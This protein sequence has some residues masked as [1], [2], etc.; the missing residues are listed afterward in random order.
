VP[1]KKEERFGT[2][3]LLLP[4]VEGRR[5]SRE[6]GHDL[7]TVRR[8]ETQLLDL[9]TLRGVE[10]L[11]QALLLRL[12]IEDGE[13]A[14][15]GHPRYGSRLHKLIGQP[16][17]ESNRNLVKLYVLEALGAEPRIKEIRSVSVT[18]DPKKRFLVEIKVNLAAIDSDTPLNLVFPFSFDGEANR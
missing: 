12:L 7:A 5:S 11:M 2:D 10:N 14:A 4:S 15:L 1:G 16:N 9:A 3:L 8:P 18:T 17:T 13:L 6:P